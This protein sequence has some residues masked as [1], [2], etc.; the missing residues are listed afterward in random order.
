MLLRAQAHAEIQRREVRERAK[1]DLFTFATLILNYSDFYEPL[2]RPLCEFTQRPEETLTLIPR[3]CFKSTVSSVSYP[4]WLLV[5]YPDT[6]ILLCN[7]GLRNPRKWVYEMKG[8][9]TSNAVMR[10]VFPE[11]C[12]KEE[13]VQQFGFTESFTV[14][15]RSEG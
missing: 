1:D 6:R 3:G 10:W 4:L 13:D 8:H 11:S 2:H 14:P 7:S 5:K 12:P 9:L 15:N